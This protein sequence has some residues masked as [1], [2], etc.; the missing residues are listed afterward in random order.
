MNRNY[1]RV[2]A[3][4]LVV[5]LSYSPTATAIS[6]RDRDA[7]TGPRERIVRIVKKVKNFFRGISS[8]DEWIPP[9]P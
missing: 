1:P 5:C 9:K 6:A 8:H 7:I 4:A 2:A 3:L